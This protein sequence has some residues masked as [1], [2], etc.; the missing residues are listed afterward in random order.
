[1]KNRKIIAITTGDP[2]SSVMPGVITHAIYD[3]VCFTTDKTLV[4]GIMVSQ[5]TTPEIIFNL[6]I[7]TGLTC[8]TILILKKV[9][10]ARILQI[11]K[12]KWSQE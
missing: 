7:V 6:V 11:C 12:D 10:S 3:Y 8:A 4:S 2:A 1:M 9:G 5:L